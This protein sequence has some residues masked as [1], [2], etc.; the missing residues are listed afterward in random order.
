ML[1]PFSRRLL[2][3]L[4]ALGILGVA[5]VSAYDADDEPV[6][7]KTSKKK[8]SKK[9]RHDDDYWDESTWD[10]DEVEPVVKKKK[11]KKRKAEKKKKKTAD[12]SWDSWED[13]DEDE[14]DDES[15]DEEE[16]D[17]FSDAYSGP[18][19]DDEEEAGD[20]VEMEPEDESEAVPEV[21]APPAPAPE[22]PRRRCI[23]QLAHDEAGAE[24]VTLNVVHSHWQNPV[25]LNKE[26]RV[27]VNLNHFRDVATVIEFT[28]KEL[29]VKWDA[30]GEERFLRQ[31]DDRYVLASMVKRTESALTRKTK[32]VATRLCSRAAVS[33]D[34][35][36]WSG[37]LLD[38]VCGNEP[39]L[40]YDE[41]RLVRGKKDLKV[42]FAEEAMVMVR[43]G[44]T[45]E[46]AAVLAYTGLKLH[47]RWDSGAVESYRRQDDGTYH[48]VDDESVARELLAPG[49]SVLKEE[50]PGWFQFWWQ[51]LMNEEPP[52]SYVKVDMRKGEETFTVRLS[53]DDMVLVQDAP[54]DRWAKVAR[55]DRNT[56]ILRWN[57]QDEELYERNA[58]GEYVYVK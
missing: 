30:Y 53:E 33:R 19:A 36:G 11:K 58:L 50:E 55:F 17:F 43:L 40:L 22:D 52:L 2:A 4:L 45:R 23:R 26:H 21:V 51:D 44:P 14:A 7:R 3:A 29:H 13:W 54:H 15:A 48:L 49:K 20:A 8:K 39:P 24:Y 5:P 10:D 16:K 9:K 57:G 18:G 32:R 56:L 47:V 28:E 27:L 42:R 41:I 34:S 31:A 35:Y 1:I 46:P 25:R 37:R 38:Y 6:M 12:D